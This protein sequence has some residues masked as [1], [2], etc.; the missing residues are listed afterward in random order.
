M[1]RKNSCVSASASYFRIVQ[2]TPS[3]TRLTS[4]SHYLSSINVAKYL[5]TVSG[6]GRK[7]GTFTVRNRD[8]KSDIKRARWD[9]EDPVWHWELYAPKD[10][11]I[12][13]KFGRWKSKYPTGYPYNWEKNPARANSHSFWIQLD[14]PV[15]FVT[16]IYKHFTLLFIPF[17]LV[18]IIG[19]LWDP[20]TR[21]RKYI[22][23]NLVNVTLPFDGLYLE[24]GGD[25]DADP[26]ELAEFRYKTAGHPKYGV[27]LVDKLHL[28]DPIRMRDPV[29]LKYLPKNFVVPPLKHEADYN[30]DMLK[31][32]YDHSQKLAR[33]NEHPMFRMNIVPLNWPRHRRIDIEYKND[34]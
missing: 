27:S 25:P 23:S 31:E 2:L 9:D 19:Y 15:S 24:Q 7:G 16:V 34:V 21:Y 6:W 12:Y 17:I 29:L 5:S 8:Q 13:D 1:W 26:K 10:P 33:R 18:L 14:Q 22:L 32:F 4:S 28:A 30:S 20:T 3:V 11:S